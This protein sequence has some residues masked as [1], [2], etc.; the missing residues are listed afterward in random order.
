[1]KIEQFIPSPKWTESAT[2]EQLQDWR[3]RES[4][5]KKNFGYVLE[6]V[7]AESEGKEKV[8][9]TTFLG[10]S[11]NGSIERAALILIEKLERDLNVKIIRHKVMPY[12]NGGKKG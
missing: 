5:E 3:K 2:V 1:M 12:C 8:V 11:N 6:V 9:E 4:E 10:L 7:Y